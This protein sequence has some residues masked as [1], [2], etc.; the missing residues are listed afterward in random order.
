MCL[1]P[2]HFLPPPSPYPPY[3]L[4]HLASRTHRVL[5]DH[6]FPHA[7][8]L[9]L[10]VRFPRIFF[11][12][13]SALQPLPLPRHDAQYKNLPLVPSSQPPVVWT[14]SISSLTFLSFNSYGRT[15]LTSL[16]IAVYIPSI[17]LSSWIWTWRI[18][19]CTVCVGLTARRRL[20]LFFLGGEDG[21]LFI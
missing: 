14:I 5:Y 9:D 16:T 21:C 20:V 4:I 3:N 7:W 1:I 6:H 17:Y 2:I 15:S 10:I 8:R 13:G 18:A 19:V 12:S 11:S